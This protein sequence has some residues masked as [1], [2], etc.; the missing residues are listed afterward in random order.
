M[1]SAMVLLNTVGLPIFGLGGA[2]TT[3]VLLGIGFGSA[4]GFLVATMLSM[5]VS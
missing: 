3:S 1:V 4:L 5:C 2:T